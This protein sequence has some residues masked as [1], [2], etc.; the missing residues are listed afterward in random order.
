MLCFDR[1]EPPRPSLETSGAR[2]Q[3]F[4]PSSLS[5]LCCCRLQNVPPLHCYTTELP[6]ASSSAP[7]IDATARN[8]RKFVGGLLGQA[9]RRGARWEEAAEAGGQHEGAPRGPRG[10]REAQGSAIVSQQALQLPRD[11]LSLWGRLLPS[12]SDLP[13]LARLRGASRAS[14]LGSKASVQSSQS[15]EG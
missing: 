14:A 4:S 15:E 7:S 9:P 12:F 10:A 2:A 11:E 5:I 6:S 1:F 13:H 3:R 8:R